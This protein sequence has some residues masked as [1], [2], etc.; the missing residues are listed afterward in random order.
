MPKLPE[1]LFLTGCDEKTEWQLPWF[2]E[3]YFEYNNTPIAIGNFGMSDEMVR[4]CETKSR[5]FCLMHHD[6]VGQFEKA[7]FLKPAAML[8]APGK[9]V[10]WLDTDC[11]VMA[12]LDHIFR[13]LVPNKLNMVMDRPWLKRRKEE[14][15]NSGVVGFIN[16]PEILHKWAKQVE[17]TPN[18]GD[19]EVLHSMLDPLNRQIYIHELPNKWN[20]LRLQIEHDNEDSNDKKIMHWTGAKGNDRIKGLM[21]IKEVIRA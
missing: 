9:K 4:W 7:W 11:Q 6:Q 5:A 8:K 1:N 18:V 16:K 15:F 2:L 20:W 12:N 21:K 17:D 13:I 10:V 14:W 19:Q 3:N